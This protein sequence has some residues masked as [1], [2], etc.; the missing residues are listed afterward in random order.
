MAN[1]KNRS[2]LL[3]MVAT[4]AVAQTEW[5]SKELSSDFNMKYKT[6]DDCSSVSF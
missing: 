1:T 6:N 3:A 5:T 2:A 4:M